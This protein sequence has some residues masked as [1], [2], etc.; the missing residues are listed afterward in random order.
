MA[1]PAPGRPLG[2][3]EHMGGQAAHGVANIVNLIVNLT[4]WPA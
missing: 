1:M 4:I 3:I 2:G